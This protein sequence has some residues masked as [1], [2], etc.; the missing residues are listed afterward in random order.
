MISNFT[1]NWCV[2]TTFFRWYHVD[3]ILY[4]LLMRRC[5]R[6]SFHVRELCWPTPRLICNLSLTEGSTMWVDIATN[7]CLNR[8]YINCNCILFAS[9][10]QVTVSRLQAVRQAFALC[11]IQKAVNAAALF[12]KNSICWRSKLT[13]NVQKMAKIEIPRAWWPLVRWIAVTKKNED[14]ISYLTL[15]QSSCV[16]IKSSPIN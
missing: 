10:S 3:L 16:R 9:N 8:M 12:Y 13:A 6:I 11:T 5:L 7:T 4:P 14:E 2:Q 1:N 15:C